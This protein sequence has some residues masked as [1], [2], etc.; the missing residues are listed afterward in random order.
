[1]GFLEEDMYRILYEYSWY[2]F[3]CFVGKYWYLGYYFD[4]ERLKSFKNWCYENIVRKMDLVVVG[5][6]YIG[7]ED[8]CV[9]Y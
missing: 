8:R 9:C 7:I 3:K 5:L 4:V 1:M 6:F 2:F